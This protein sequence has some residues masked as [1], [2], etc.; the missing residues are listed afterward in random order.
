MGPLLVA[1]F[2]TF[3]QIP[4]NDMLIG[5][6]SSNAWRS[7]FYAM[8][9]TIGLSIASIAYWLIALSHESSL[10]FNMMLTTLALVMCAAVG[11]AVTLVYFK[12]APSECGES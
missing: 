8:K 3:A 5:K 7:R 2:L 9:Y 1:I 6:N 12:K 4:V 11:A 10:G